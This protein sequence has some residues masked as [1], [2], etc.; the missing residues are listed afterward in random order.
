MEVVSK[1]DN[2]ENVFYLL[3]NQSGSPPGQDIGN[4]LAPS[5]VEATSG[6]WNERIPLDSQDS[7]IHLKNIIDKKTL[8]SE[9][10]LPTQQ[11][12]LGVD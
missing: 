4:K 7:T 12:L 6:I 11:C 3:A 1:E 5:P 9:D 10:Q 8:K 2:V